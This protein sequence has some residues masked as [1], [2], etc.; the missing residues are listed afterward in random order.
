MIVWVQ[1]LVETMAVTCLA[2]LTGGA[3]LSLVADE[4]KP[5]VVF[6]H[7]LFPLAA[8]LAGLA[9]FVPVLRLVL[10]LAPDTGWMEAIRLG[11]F[12]SRTGQVWLGLLAASVL[13]TLFLQARDITSSKWTA[14]L[15]LIGTWMLILIKSWMGHAA[16]VSGVSGWVLHSVHLTAV[17]IWAGGLMMAGFFTVDTARWLSFLRWFTPTAIGCVTAVILA[18]WGLMGIIAPEYIASWVLPYGEALLLKQWMTAGVLVMAGVNGGWIRRKLAR[19]EGVNPLPWI[20]AEA[21]LI[22]LVVAIT[23][24]MSQEAAPHTVAETV[25]AVGLSPLFEGLFP[26]KWHPGLRAEWQGHLL[27]GLSV[28]VAL[29]L[30]AL[31]PLLFR[32]GRSAYGAV[33]LAGLAACVGFVGVLVWAYGG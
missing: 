29:I 25:Q 11:V 12:L 28:L 1:T 20:R 32:Q 24:W 9:S 18:G 6:P 19:G 3:L 8:L 7:R 22:L 33:W 21:I 4:Y 14:G 31:I 16:S 17:C 27:G 30:L 2:L 5:V 10:F 26:G 13:L 23:A 15:A